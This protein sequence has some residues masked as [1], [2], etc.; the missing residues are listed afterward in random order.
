MDVTAYIDGLLAR[1]ERSPLFGDAAFPGLYPLY[2]DLQVLRAKLEQPLHAAVI[3]EVKAGKSTLINAFAGGE[4]SPTNAT[5]TTACIM[6][7]SYSPEEKPYCTSLMERRR[8]ARWQKS[9]SCW[10]H[11]MA[12]RRSSAAAGMWK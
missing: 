8:K 10:K 5:E 1:A 11:I 9:M 6:K 12:I 3:G 7:I 4:I 2:N